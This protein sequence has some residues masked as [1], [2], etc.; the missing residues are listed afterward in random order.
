MKGRSVDAP[1]RTEGLTKV[2]KGQRGEVRAVNDMSLSLAAGE[3]FGLLGPNGAGKSTTIGMLTTRVLPTAGRAFISGIDVVRHAARVKRIIG[4]VQQ[5]N[6][7]DRALT[8]S[9]NLEYH[10]RFFG[11]SSHDAKQRSTELL[12]RFALADRAG[13]MVFEL[14]GG[15]AQRLMIAR[16]LV[17]RPAILFLDEPTSGID[18]QTRVNLWDIL[19]SLHA[20]GQTIL[21]TTHYMEE[22]DALCERVAV[23]DHG[24]ILADGSPAELKRSIGADTV[25]TLVFNGDAAVVAD[26]AEHLNGVEKVEREGEKIRVFARESDGLL[27][28][29]I[30]TGSQS[31]LSVLDASS[32]LPS[33]ETVFLELT[34]REYRE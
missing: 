11:M 18:P 13:G 8:V 16:A 20:E 2:Y 19:R 32:L 17:H 10:G 26:R 24:R 33:L 9:E 12:E 1:I 30:E 4:V 3:F 21:L 23:M 34:G 14:S 25:L 31:G 29:L 6:T 28:T 5:T 7:L 27:G 22:A 15:L